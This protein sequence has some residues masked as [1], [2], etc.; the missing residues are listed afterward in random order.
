MNNQAGVILIVAVCAGVLLLG[1][2]KRHAE[3]LLNFVLR[4]V[5]GCIAIFLLNMLLKKLGYGEGVALNLITVLTSGILG[6][7]G[8]CLLFGIYFYKSM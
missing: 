6:F 5:L 8:V 4:T 1:A 2:M 7:P 3:W